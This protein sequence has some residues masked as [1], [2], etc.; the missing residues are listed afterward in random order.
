M[1][2]LGY[3]LLSAQYY[4]MSIIHILIVCLPNMKYFKIIH[5]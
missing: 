3:Y 4:S 1:D 5:F 2:F